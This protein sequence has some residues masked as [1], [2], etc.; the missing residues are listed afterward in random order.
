MIWQVDKAELLTFFLVDEDW[1][2]G[3]LLLE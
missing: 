1:V 3:G 2:A